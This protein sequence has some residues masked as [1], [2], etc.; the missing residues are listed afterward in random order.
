MGKHILLV[1]SLLSLVAYSQSSLFE[2]DYRDFL[3]AFLSNAEKRAIIKNA[4]M[5]NSW[6]ISKEQKGTLKTDK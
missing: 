4:L 6:V 2:F 1:L 3:Q 5:I